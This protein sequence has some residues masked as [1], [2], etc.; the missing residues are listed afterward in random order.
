MDDSVTEMANWGHLFYKNISKTQCSIKRESSISDITLWSL[1]S[2]VFTS[3]IG[4]KKG[5]SELLHHNSVSNVTEIHW[6]TWQM[7]L[8][9]KTL[10]IMESMKRAINCHIKIFKNILKLHIPTRS[11]TSFNTSSP[12]WKIMPQKLLRPVTVFSMRNGLLIT[13]KSLDWIL[14]LI[15]IFSH[16]LFKSILILVF[17]CHHHCWLGSFHIWYK[18][19]SG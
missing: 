19:C 9:K 10:L 3:S 11:I 12:K 7:T 13:L 18:M 14:W 4:T 2:T 8:Y 5:I 16:G 1:A 17:S 15:K 6:F